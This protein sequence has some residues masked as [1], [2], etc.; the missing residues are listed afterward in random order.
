MPSWWVLT[1]FDVTPFDSW[2]PV[3]GI[4][5]NA[6]GGPRATLG[7][8]VRY[9]VRDQATDGGFSTLHTQTLYAE[10]SDASHPAEIA[11]L[12]ST[13]FPY[14][15]F[16]PLNSTAGISALSLVYGYTNRTTGAVV[17]LFLRN[18]GRFDTLVVLARKRLASL[19][20]RPPASAVWRTAQAAAGGLKRPRPRGFFPSG[21]DAR[22]RRHG[23]F[24]GDAVAP[25]P[26]P[27]VKLRV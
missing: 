18:H 25:L 9:D 17:P 12:R 20:A 13:P 19:G 14:L 8:A 10:T 16:H 7:P 11:G 3:D 23:P 6:G 1:A 4:V 2:S 24:G 27:R 26:R 21:G 15:E 5:V 22:R